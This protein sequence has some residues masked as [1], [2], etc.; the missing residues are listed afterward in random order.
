MCSYVIPGHEIF[1]HTSYVLSVCLQEELNR[2]KAL[3]DQSERHLRDEEERMGSANEQLLKLTELKNALQQQA[4]SG[5][6][7]LVTDKQVGSQSNLP[8]PF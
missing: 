1:D 8:C 7:G 3:L 5:G 2:V 6:S 4:D